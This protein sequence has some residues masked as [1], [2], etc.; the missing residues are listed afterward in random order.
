MANTTISTDLTVFD[1][2]AALTD[3]LPCY[4]SPNWIVSERED[5][6]PNAQPFMRSRIRIP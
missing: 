3:E 5:V 2:L 1:L 4:A 6:Q